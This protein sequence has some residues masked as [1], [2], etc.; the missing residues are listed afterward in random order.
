MVQRT[1]II[2]TSAGE[3]DTIGDSRDG[4]PN[5]QQVMG[6]QVAGA[7]TPVLLNGTYGSM[8]SM[9]LDGETRPPSGETE[10]RSSGES[11]RS[12]RA[13][14]EAVVG[15][16][17]AAAGRV[18]ANVAAK[19]QGAIPPAGAD[20]ASS[21]LSPEDGGS[22][23]TAE[24]GYVTVAS[25][26][27]R[28]QR[29]TEDAPEAAGSGL[30]SPQQARRLQE[31]Q[32]EAPLLYAEAMLSGIVQLQNVVADL[33]A[34]KQG[35]VE[36]VKLP[37]PTLEGECWDK[38]LSEA[39][40]WYNHQFVP[41][42]PIARVRLKAP[43]SSIDK[44]LRQVQHPRP[45]D[46]AID[47]V[48]KLRTWRRWMTRLTDLGL[49]WSVHHY[50][51]MPS[52]LLPRSM[53]TLSPKGESARGVRQ[54]EAR[55]AAGQ[56]QLEDLEAQVLDGSPKVRALQG[57]SQFEEEP[58][59]LLD[60]GATHAVLDE[61]SVRAQ[62]LVPCT[63]SLAGDQRQVWQQTPGG[64]LVAPSNESGNVPQT[65]LP[66]GCLVEQLGCT[67]KWSKKLGLHLVHP[68]LGRL[69]TSLKGG[70]PQL[71]KDQALLL[72][73]ELEKARLGELTSRLRKVQAQLKACTG[74][75]LQDAIDEFVGCGSYTSALSLSQ[76]MPFLVGLP[77]RVVTRLPVDLSET[78]G[79][80]VLKGLPFNR[81]FRKR[82][83][84]SHAWLLHFSSGPAD[85]ALRGLCKD[86]GVE[87]VEL[88]STSLLAPEVWQALSW[89]AFTGRVSG[90][91]SEALMRTWSGIR[92]NDAKVVR[93]RDEKHPWGS[94]CNDAAHQLRVEDDTVLA[95]RPL[96]LWTLSSIAR[97]EGIPICQVQSL[98]AECVCEPWMN[99]V[100]APF[101]E[102]SNCSRFDVASVRETAMV[103]KPLHV[104]TNLGF[105]R[106]EE[107]CQ[108]PQDGQQPLPAVPVWPSKFKRELSLALFGIATE[109]SSPGMSRVK[110]VDGQVA[111]DQICL[112]E[113]EA[114][115]LG[116]PFQ[117]LQED[118]AQVPGSLPQGLHAEGV[119]QMHDKAMSRAVGS[120]GVP[121]VTSD[122]A[123]NPVPKL[124]DKDREMWKRHLASH[125]IPF[126]KDCLQCVMSGSLGV[127]HRRVKCP[128]M[129]ALAFDMTGPF[130]ELGRDDRGSGY[131]YALVA[132]LRIPE[133]ALPP[134]QREAMPKS[135][136]DRSVTP[137]AV[138]IESQ[139]SEALK[140][141]DASSEASW[142][143][144]DLEP[145]VV[146]S[147]VDGDASDSDDEQRSEL[148]W[149]EAPDVDD[150]PDVT[151]GEGNDNAAGAYLEGVVLPAQP[152][153]EGD[154]W[155]DAQGMSAISD[156]AFDEELS[157]MIFTG[158]NQVLRFVVPLK[159]RQ[160]PQI[161]AGLQ[162]VVTE[163]NRLGYPVKIAHT[164]RAKELMSKATMDWLQSKLI[165]P[166][167]TQGDD[168]KSNG[169]AERL[170]G[171]YLVAK[172]VRCVDNL[173]NPEAELGDEGV[174]E[175]ELTEDKASEVIAEELLRP[176]LAE[177]QLLPVTRIGGQF[178]L[179]L[180]LGATVTAEAE[181]AWTALTV[182][183]AD[184]CELDEEG[185]ERGF[186]RWQRVLG[187]Q[188][189]DPALDPLSG[190]IPHHLFMATV[191]QQ[192]DWTRDPELYLPTADGRRLLAYVFQ[193]SDDGYVDDTPFPDRML[194]FSIRDMIRDVEEMVILRVE[195]IQ[196][197]VG[198]AELMQPVLQPPGPPPPQVQAVT[199]LE[200]EEAVPKV[201]RLPVPLP[202]PT[203][204][205]VAST[206][207]PSILP[208]QEGV[209]VRKTEATTTKD[210]E[211]LL[212]QLTEPLSVTHTASQEEVR[213]NLG[214]WKAA[215]EKELDS[216]KGPGVLVSHFG[217]EARDMIANPET[218]VI[219][220]KGVFTA[221]A[222]SGPADG[223]FRR[224]CRLVGC[225]N[226]STHVDADS[227][228]AAGAPAEL[229]RASLTQA[230]R[231][232]WSAFT[233]D[234]RSAFTQTPIPPHAARRYLLRPPR[235]L[236]DL[237]L[238]KADEYYSLG[239]VLYG[240]KEA[241]A[242][243]SEHRDAKLRT[244]SFLGCRLEQGKS[245]ASIWR[246]ME[247]NVIKGYLVTYVDDFL[248]L[249]DKGIAQGLHRWIIDK[250]GWETDGLSE[251][252][253]GNPV[254]FL[255]MQLQRYEDGHFSLD[256]EAYIDELVRAH[257]LGEGDKSKI[258]CPRET[259]MCE[260][261]VVQP[262][263]ESTVRAAQKVA[264]ECL[265]L[266]QRSRLDVAFAT[267]ML[268]SRVSRDP[269]GAL[270]IGRRILSYLNQTK[271]YR[272]H[273][274]PDES[275][276]P[277]RIFT[278]ASFSPQ[279]QHSFGGHIIEVFG[280]PV[281]WKASRQ[282][283]IA[284]SS[285][286]AE[287]IQAVE[288]CT[289]AESLMTVLVDLGLHCSTAELQ[290]DNTAC[291]AFIN[292]AGNQRTRHLKVRYE[293]TG[294][295][296][297]SIE[298]P[299]ELGV[300]TLLVILST[301]FL[302][303]A[304]G[305]PCRRRA[306]DVP[307]V[308][309]LSVPKA[310]R[311][312][313]KLQERVAAAIDS[314]MSESP[315]GD[316]ARTEGRKGRNKCSSNFAQVE[317]RPLS[318]SPTVVYGDLNM[319]WSQASSEQTGPP[320]SAADGPARHYT[321]EGV[322]ATTATSYPFQAPDRVALEPSG[323]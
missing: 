13:T 39:Q 128:Q 66:L 267:T 8:G 50:T 259:L 169:L 312:S 34:N 277:I 288:G 276:G 244:A 43:A 146:V 82:L 268:C 71:N 311:R 124:S 285:S 217:Q 248:I 178:G 262:Y 218:T 185:F 111:E 171:G 316:E 141:D 225:G 187:G 41:A 183:W 227:L 60:S 303:E 188:N 21:F 158:A 194:M 161:L 264:G 215:I 126:R 236:V 192:R 157:S 289:Y 4:G 57:L 122:V 160:G 32:Q 155:D 235:W 98:Q 18:M 150:V 265:W 87:L 274:K 260:S 249:S 309:A 116:L 56:A 308:R 68:R 143:K 204:I 190:S 153:A 129:F 246:I 206:S 40:E 197:Q 52:R 321:A 84:Q 131:K 173:V 138:A 42:N 275:A 45:A 229:V 107:E 72:I 253:P 78:N 181:P 159:S 6:A 224:K 234:I 93:L 85:S 294:D 301:L 179:Q 81:G 104:C 280:V 156:E 176:H 313:K 97:G 101:A 127:Q 223:L 46:S 284:L 120:G 17:R 3:T 75:K 239:M 302:W 70:C 33:A 263:D 5:P 207:H 55:V 10:A 191:F 211:G 305:A 297:V 237:G 20:T 198:Q 137:G 214:K 228:Y 134:R 140:D 266:S 323:P 182:E 53:N 125:H 203:C 86:R 200:S 231:H 220:L 108:T 317:P 167:F 299:W 238:A 175:A 77:Q 22:A 148:S 74:V 67:I 250:A 136:K 28:D 168:P 310:E 15:T 26:G 226:Q 115:V 100:I 184:L 221:K 151:P 25:G 196:E 105:P 99:A 273:L 49:I 286:E 212:N 91:V 113:D 27:D 80:E 254:R 298:W 290:L 119:G 69:R 318:N 233:T 36:L 7:R 154:P 94:P 272:M 145:T 222:P 314:A 118:E 172:N 296:G 76:L 186:A 9:M 219:S 322:H 251:A 252:T 208:S 31:M 295:G 210:L 14:G 300:L 304:S 242:W 89:A 174:L 106:I 189:E 1:Q 44:A 38:V 11:G 245:D 102:W 258:V 79:W 37:A 96:W 270:A 149:F 54:V 283:L 114:Q 16:L 287:L 12:G 165:Q 177:Q 282:A 62:D 166:S 306:E 240:F 24:T 133:E 193:F 48:L 109:S 256:Q 319:H 63:V 163:C 201:T 95:L 170:V 257:G 279:G 271:D 58:T 230:S 90:I 213:A 65:I 199:A 241:P 278:D 162:E 261:E 247:G 112:P 47:A 164:D 142:L 315:T 110:A 135:K 195:L 23:G 64:S 320:S 92:V 269:H 202:N 144:A 29:A 117:G 51:W 130:K 281:L 123:P 35:V 291:I 83:H 209:C 2:M 243:W 19:V 88:T 292:G 103:T 73:K 139:Q 205:G 147:K 30:F 132:G 121:G 216:L 255:G 61:S 232:Q 59:A 152:E 307:R 293:G 180:C